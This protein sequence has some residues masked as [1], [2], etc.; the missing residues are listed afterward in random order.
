[1]N[2][3]RVIFRTLDLTFEP[4]PAILIHNYST[5]EKAPNLLFYY[6]ISPLPLISIAPKG[7]NAKLEVEKALFLYHRCQVYISRLQNFK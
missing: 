3:V 6:L 1:V 4:F 7:F 5:W 2:W